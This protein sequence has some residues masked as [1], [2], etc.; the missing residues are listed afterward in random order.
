M[1]RAVSN[2]QFE[3]NT[4]RPM[5]FF[6]KRHFETTEDIVENLCEQ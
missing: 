3:E 5:P 2:Q 4:S 6:A 1:S